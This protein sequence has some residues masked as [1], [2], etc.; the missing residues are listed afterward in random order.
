MG[1][2]DSIASNPAQGGQSAPPSAGGWLTNIVRLYQQ[3]QAQDAATT[4]QIAGM[5]PQLQQQ[6]V[7]LSQDAQ[8]LI[9]KFSSGKASRSDKISL[10]GELQSGIAMKQQQAN[11]ALPGA[12]TALLQQQTAGAQ[13]GNVGAALTQLQNVDALNQQRAASGQPL[14]PTAQIIQQ[15]LNMGQN[16]QGGQSGAS[17]GQAPYTPSPGTLSAFG[18]TGRP[19][20]AAGTAGPQTNSTPLP[21]ANPAP[22]IDQMP[23]L[24]A[25]DPQSVAAIQQ[26]SRQL[27]PQFGFDRGKAADAA[28][29]IIQ[30][31]LDQQNA[32]EQPIGWTSGGFDANTAE[33]LYNRVFAKRGNN[34]RLGTASTETARFPAGTV[35]NDPKNPATMIGTLLSQTAGGQYIPAGDALK[36]ATSGPNGEDA[37]PEG[38]MIANSVPQQ[39][40]IKT[41][42]PIFQQA[43]LAAT[44]A[45]VAN[46]VAQAYYAKNQNALANLAKG[47]QFGAAAIAALND[48]PTGQQFNALVNK[49]LIPTLQSMKG[50]GAIR[51]AEIPIFQGGLATASMGAA[52]GSDIADLNDKMATLLMN[53]QASTLANLRAGWRPGEA[54]ARAADQNPITPD[55]FTPLSVKK[56]QA[57]A[58]AAHMGVMV[59]RFRVTPHNN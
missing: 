20:N 31:N 1:L 13:L 45:K 19:A 26:L 10:L 30:K 57:A 14:I 7:P 23:L 49:E 54:A 38:A 2:L 36:A 22:R 40:E 11:I 27:L 15:F 28:T 46:Q 18:A 37:P 24:S 16:S 3:Q 42:I 34:I 4:G 55:D 39:N 17:G 59:G 29:S 50:T 53:R 8:G 48:D 41:Q 44:Q 35:I 43:A 12:Q 6:G 9:Q 56:A 52:A 21:Q 47:S 5:L 51:S 58:A 25:S 33:D 32:V